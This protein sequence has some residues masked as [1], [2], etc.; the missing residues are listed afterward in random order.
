MMNEQTLTEQYRGRRYRVGERVI[1][2][3]HVNFVAGE[4]YRVFYNAD[5]PEDG[6]TGQ[7]SV[8]LDYLEGLPEIV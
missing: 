1:T 5:R 7:G 8:F 2:I 3:S 4:T 6:G